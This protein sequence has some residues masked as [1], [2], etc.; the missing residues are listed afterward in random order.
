MEL[1]Q[2]FFERFRG[3]S[4]AYGGYKEGQRN[5]RGKLEGEA[6]V[7]R[8]ELTVDNW[9]HHLAGEASLGVIPTTDDN[10]CYWGA[11]DID[12]KDYMK[13][14]DPG[15]LQK[16]IDLPMIV[17][18]SKSGGAHVYLFFSEPVPASK[19]QQRM[20]EI[21]VYLGLPGV[22]VNPKQTA[23]QPDKGTVG[24]YLNMP[25]FG[26]ENS[27]RIGYR[28]DGT[29]I[30]DPSE[31]LDR[32]D[33]MAI[34]E[35]QLDNLELVSDN[36]IEDGPPCL[37]ALAQN[38][39]PQGQRNNTMLNVGVYLKLRYGEDWH[40]VF[41]KM[42]Y[43]S[44]ILEEPLP[45]GEINTLEKQVD[46]GYFYGC[47]HEPIASLCQK[48]ICKQRKYGVGTNSDN[49]EIAI[50]AA[51][52]VDTTPP[53]YYITVEGGYQLILTSE[54]LLTPERFKR[55]YFET[56][57][58]IPTTG[59]KPEWEQ[60][61]NTIMREA[62]LV[63]AP[64]DVGME[65]QILMLLERFIQESPPANDRNEILQGKP[66]FHEGY[67]YFKGQ[68]L[69][70]F[71]KRERSDMSNARSQQIFAYIRS[72]YGEDYYQGKVRLK[73]RPTAVWGVPAPEVQTEGY[74]VPNVGS[75]EEEY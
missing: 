34:S 58:Q 4:R 67:V 19:A 2:R 43:T 20:T 66:W 31:F 33:E 56:L 26:G 61:I 50:E 32:C 47:S 3:L 53:V 28:S 10:T 1:A 6:Y 65:G 41:E 70:E 73:G 49:P 55:M 68:S 72:H 22:E 60:Y 37:Q 52:K 9:R 62:T 18:R 14:E 54:D 25:Y 71:I 45:S 7:V 36:L 21:S 64:D 44:G 69:L 30:T 63:E 5:A 40:P 51:H 24:N 59:K 8:D 38:G 11:L 57:D 29:A 46:K 74:D 75:K 16:R 12:P 13:A 42:N 27:T 35:E 48:R 15:E 17:C 23:Q 39:V